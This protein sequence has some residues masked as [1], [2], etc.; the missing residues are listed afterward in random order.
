MIARVLLASC[1]ALSLVACAEREQNASG[2]K[3]DQPTF[4]GTGTT[5]PYSAVDWKQGDKTSWE[6]QLRVRGQGQ[7]EYVRIKQQ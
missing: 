3:S 5:T 2:V 4:A 1:A 7:N 6:H